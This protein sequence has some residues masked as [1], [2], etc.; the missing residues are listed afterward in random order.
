MLQLTQRKSYISGARRASG[1]FDTSMRGHSQVQMSNQW[2]VK[3][4]FLGSCFNLFLPHFRITEDSDSV[5][6]DQVGQKKWCGVLITFI[7]L[8]IKEEKLFRNMWTKIFVEKLCSLPK[9]HIAT[10]VIS[11]KVISVWTIVQNFFS[12]FIFFPHATI[13]ARIFLLV[14]FFI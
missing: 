7:R 12:R 3:S 11:V 5:S 14:F 2:T 9:F 8:M 6:L 4:A 1:T 13:V 10:Q